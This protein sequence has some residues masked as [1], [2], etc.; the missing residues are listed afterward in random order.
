MSSSTSFEKAGECLY[1]NPS[2]QQYYALLKIR[3]KQIKRSLKT[4]VVAVPHLRDGAFLPFLSPNGANQPQPRATPWE[5]APAA[6][7]S[8]AL[9]GV[10]W[11]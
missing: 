10:E 1:R 3:G 2:S 4:R 7:A 11:A 9:S 8:R 5:N 6:A